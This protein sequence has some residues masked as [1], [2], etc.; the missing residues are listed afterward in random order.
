MMLCKLSVPGRPTK[1]DNSKGLLCLQRVRVGAVQIFSSR[2]SFFF[3]VPLSG[4]RL[5]YCLKAPF[6]TQ[7]NQRT[8][9]YFE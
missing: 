1:V 2:L 6:T 3:S 8:Y 9:C 5:N 7:N 4:Y